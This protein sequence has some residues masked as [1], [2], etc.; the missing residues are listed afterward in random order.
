[1]DGSAHAEILGKQRKGF[2]GV[3]AGRANETRGPEKAGDLLVVTWLSWD[4]PEAP[5]L[6]CPR[7][8][9]AREKHS[10]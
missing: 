6:F 3:Q 7:A 2:P 4:H 10:S 8:G 5:V 9:V 1:M